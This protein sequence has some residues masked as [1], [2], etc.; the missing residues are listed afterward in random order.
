[1]AI[2][3]ET[4]KLT[5]DAGLTTSAAQYLDRSHKTDESDNPQDS[6]F[7]MG[8][9]GSAGG[10]TADRQLQADSDPGVANIVITPT[11]ILPQWVVATAYVLNQG[12]EPIT[13]NGFRY[14]CTTAG[15]SHA[16][17]EPVWPTGIGS[18]IT[19]NTAVWVC[20]SAIHAVTEITLGITQAALA[21]NTPGAA[22]SLGHTLLS[23]TSNKKTIWVRVINNVNTV[24]NNTA[25]P[26][27]A[28]IWNAFSEYEV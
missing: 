25:T 16:T 20:V 6:T 26:E 11:Y 4:F 10:D 9:L 7:Y 17:T 5:S 28:L 1:M 19:D 27:L 2:F 15:T 14:K 12:L 24:G 3:T 18:S 8:S 13:P 23:G 22:L 21:V